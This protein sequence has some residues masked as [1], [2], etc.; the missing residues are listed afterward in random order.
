MRIC[1]FSGL[2]G[3]GQ[4]IFQRR[5]RAVVDRCIIAK[6]I[7]TA[8]EIKDECFAFWFMDFQEPAG[9]I[10]LLPIGGIAEGNKQNV[11]VRVVFVKTEFKS[12]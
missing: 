7:E 4:V 1:L 3:N 5:K 10:G 9:S 11:R 6:G 8:I 12:G 2:Y